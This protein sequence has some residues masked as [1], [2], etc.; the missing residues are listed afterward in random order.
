MKTIEMIRNIIE[1]TKAR[2]AWDRAV[3]EYALE[4]L[5]EYE[6]NYGSDACAPCETD[7]LN[8]ASNWK[9]YSWGGCSLIYDRNIAQRTLF[10]FRTEKDPQRR[11]EA[12]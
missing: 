6:N 11:K 5:E 3:N 9:E 8:G 12:Q 10:P 2:S 1:T 7:L 4:L